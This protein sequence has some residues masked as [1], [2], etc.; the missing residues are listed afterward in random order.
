MTYLKEQPEG[1]QALSSYLQAAGKIKAS[2]P[3][4]NSG[5]RGEARLL[6]RG[7]GQATGHIYCRSSCIIHK[8]FFAIV[9]ALAWTSNISRKAHTHTHH[10]AV[11]GFITFYWPTLDVCPSLDRS[12]TKHPA[13]LSTSTVPLFHLIRKIHKMEKRHFACRPF[14]DIY[15]MAGSDFNFPKGCPAGLKKKKKIK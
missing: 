9:Y 2:L 1:H 5:C 8:T 4:Y 7:L 12:L 6:G 10:P 13:T 11:L 15:P 3:L 14:P